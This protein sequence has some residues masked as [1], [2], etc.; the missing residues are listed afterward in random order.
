MKKTVRKQESSVRSRTKL[1]RALLLGLDRLWSC[2]RPI[3]E[4][5]R[6]GRRLAPTVV[7]PGASLSAESFSTAGYSE[8]SGPSFRPK[9]PNGRLILNASVAT[10]LCSRCFSKN[11]HLLDEITVY[12]K[13][14]GE[15]FRPQCDI[16]YKPLQCTW[17]LIQVH[18]NHQ[19]FFSHQISH[20]YI[21]YAPCP[22]SSISTRADD[23][24]SWALYFRYIK[25]LASTSGI[26][27]LA[28]VTKGERDHQQCLS[29]I[30]L[31]G[32]PPSI[33][34]SYSVPCPNNSSPR[35]F[36][37][38]QLKGWHARSTRHGAHTLNK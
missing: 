27:A 3:S 9:V 13:F 31:Q 30:Y 25:R 24:G 10:P 21:P 12:A 8:L 26:V 19:I 22:W 37:P 29:E 11:S 35:W 33:H 32:N 6:K 23:L 36:I 7:K 34:L 28:Y 2:D 16:I 15:R 17:Y 14:I 5:L 18:N 4:L 38:C 1:R 20:P